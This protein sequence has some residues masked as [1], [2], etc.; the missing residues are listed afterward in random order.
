MFGAA[1]R[2]APALLFSHY[3][4]WDNK[5]R[6]ETWTWTVEGFSPWIT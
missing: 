1:C 5:I 3:E 2:S 4:S 6:L